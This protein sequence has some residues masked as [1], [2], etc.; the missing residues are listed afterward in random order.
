[1][2][3]KKI[4]ESQHVEFKSIH[5]GRFKAKDTND[6]GTEA[7]DLENVPSDLENDLNPEQS[8]LEKKYG[9]TVNQAKILYKIMQDNTIT[10]QKLSELVGIT[11]KN[12]RNN[13]KK[14]KEKDLLQRIGPDKG[15]YWQVF[16]NS[17]KKDET[18]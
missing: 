11:T 9:L 4:K 1:M 15:G 7:N 6:L 13:I 14:L 12:I 8:D 3:L 18:K 10:Q 16:L 5:I 2:D 17:N